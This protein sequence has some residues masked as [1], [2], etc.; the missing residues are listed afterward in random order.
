MELKKKLVAGDVVVNVGMAEEE[1]AE[2]KAKYEQQLLDME[3]MVSSTW[4]EKA[5]LSEENEKQLSRALD[6]RKRQAQLRELECQ[7]RFRLLQDQN[8]IELSIRGLLDCL[9]SLAFNKTAPRSA[10]L[11]GELPR[12]WLKDTASIVA[13]V[14]AVKEHRTTALV[15]QTAFSEDLRL[16]VDGEEASDRAMAR[17]GARRALAKLDNFRSEC[18]KLC[19]LDEQSRTKAQQ[20]A[21]AV[22]DTAKKWEGEAKALMDEFREKSGHDAEPLH[23][24]DLHVQTLGDVD[25]IL[26]LIMKQADYR[27]EQSS[28]EMRGTADLVFRG[29]GLSQVDFASTVDRDL[30]QSC[31]TESDAHQGAPRLSTVPREKRPLHEWTPE[32]A[33]GSLEGTEYTLSQLVQLESLNKKKS[34]QELLARPPPKFVHDLA[35]VVRRTTGFLPSLSEEWPEPRDARLDLLQQIADAVGSALRMDLKFDPADVLKGKEVPRTLLLLQLL[36]IAAARAAAQHDVK[37]VPSAQMPISDIPKL[38]DAMSRSVQAALK[39]WESIQDVRVPSAASAGEAS[40]T[41][42]DA[43]LLSLQERLEEEIQLRRRHEEKFGDLEKENANN[44]VVLAQ[45]TADL[46][47]C[48]QAVENSGQKK[49]E[50]RRQVEVLRAGLLQRA[51]QMDGGEITR[52]RTELEAV[53]A[54]MGDG[55]HKRQILASE[56]KKLTQQKTEI[57]TQRESME[58]E[59]KRAKLRMAE[60]LDSGVASQTEE[61]LNLQAEQQQL[62]VRVATLEEKLRALT[63]GDEE[64]QENDLIEEKKTHS[65]NNDDAQIALQVIVEERDSLREAMDQLWTDKTRVEEEL[66]NVTQGY[67][68]LSDRLLENTDVARELEDQLQKYENCLAMLQEHLGK[69]RSSP[70]TPPEDPTFLPEKQR[71]S[72]GITAEDPVSPVGRDNASSHYSDD[73]F[74]EPDDD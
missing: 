52:V 29:M 26:K 68:N 25:R 49:E 30:L 11:S 10:F 41:R 16:W 45:R 35:L 14:D 12:R 27:A 13:T 44:G 63:E 4:E 65:S 73:D 31:G 47:L 40:P 34:P 51:R 17:T 24:V 46:E 3:R 18:A 42:L 19:T 66:E 37:S 15:F 60:G 23:G 50:L 64:K 55:S 62:D 7:K 20:F 69:Q 67:T 48:R 71:S 53:S 32:D 22:L 54:R 6:E 33:D 1:R 61:I 21:T 59:V 56:V 38:L 43:T 5:R 2:M 70:G 72:P 74:E 9:R 39:H 28:L 36:A 58:L 57:D 8:D